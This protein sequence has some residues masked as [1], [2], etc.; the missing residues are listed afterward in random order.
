MFDP[1]RLGITVPE[2][3]D[4]TCDTMRRGTG[5]GDLP[6]PRPLGA[7]E[8]AEGDLAEHKGCECL[9]LAWGIE[10]AQEATNGVE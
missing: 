3:A 2:P 7:S 9:D 10:Q 1:Q 8:Q 5:C 4:G 6:E